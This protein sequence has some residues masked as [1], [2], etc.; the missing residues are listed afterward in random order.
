MTI[1]T[2][3]IMMKQPFEAVDKTDDIGRLQTD[4]T[5]F[6]DMASSVLISALQ[7]ETCSK[8][9]KSHSSIDRCWTPSKTMHRSHKD[10]KVIPAFLCQGEDEGVASNDYDDRDQQ[11]HTG[12]SKDHTQEPFTPS[13]LSTRSSNMRILEP[14]PI[15][16]VNIEHKGTPCMFLTAIQTCI[17][18]EAKDAPFK[19]E[20][21]L[22][23]LFVQYER[24]KEKEYKPTTA[25]F[26]SGKNYYP[27]C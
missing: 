7:V 3:Q 27:N 1:E 24:M 6:V 5:R 22:H 12:G 10:G 14:S 15:D 13:S 21:L 9:K 16:G 4:L 2:H 19:C 8:Y 20:E 11:I 25:I 18:N 26:N 23:R 17:R